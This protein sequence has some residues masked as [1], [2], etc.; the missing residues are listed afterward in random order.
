LIKLRTIVDFKLS[1]DG[2]FH[3]FLLALKKKHAL[4]PMDQNL[5]KKRGRKRK[6]RPEDMEANENP[7]QPPTESSQ[8][9]SVHNKP[10]KTPEEK[11]EYLRKRNA[12]IAQCDSKKQKLN[13]EISS[14][15]FIENL[16]DKFMYQNYPNYLWREEGLCLKNLE[17]YKR[18]KKG[19]CTHVDSMNWTDVITKEA[20]E[21]IVS[22][23][24]HLLGNGPLTAAEVDIFDRCVDLLKKY[25]ADRINLILHR[26]SN[27]NHY[28]SNTFFPS[29][30]SPVFE[31]FI[32]KH[33]LPDSTVVYKRKE[34]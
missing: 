3:L 28:Y 19:T 15:S 6:V 17:V 10:S 29:E 26:S 11:E 1:Q 31:I 18:I 34:A 33:E 4:S 12:K 14:D 30:T 2:Y 20:I 5:P 16:H 24:E 8:Q 27:R 25:Y 13:S 21:K 7:V 23:I 9:S 32:S 22:F